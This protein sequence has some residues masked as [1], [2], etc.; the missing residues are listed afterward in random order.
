MKQEGS[1]ARTH[2]SNP[3]LPRG[4][5]SL[6][7]DAVRAAQRERLVRAMIAVSAERGYLRITVADV[8][9][10]AKVSRAAFYAHFSD[11]TDCLLEATLYG[12]GLLIGHIRAQTGALP[13]ETPP[14]EVLRVACRAFLGFLTDEPEFARVFYVEMPSAGPLALGRGIEAH[15]AYARLNA[16]WH[17]HARRLDPSLPAVPDEAFH[18]AVGATTEL[19]RAAVHSGQTALGDLEDTLVALHLALL[20]GKVWAAPRS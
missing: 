8:V 2:E 20:A 15:H 17:R 19:V 1:L 5:A 4:R 16:A 6:P 12:R 14:E 7:A 13:E 18:A 11:K 9:A 3:G 10:R